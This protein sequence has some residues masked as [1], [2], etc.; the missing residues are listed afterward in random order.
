MKLNNKLQ[1]HFESFQ[2]VSVQVDGV[3]VG[4]GTILSEDD[5]SCK[6]PGI[7][8]PPALFTYIVGLKIRE[9]VPAETIFKMEM[10]S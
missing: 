3:Q 8:L 2:S 1:E 4:S 10:F 6:R 5:I 9:S 7:G